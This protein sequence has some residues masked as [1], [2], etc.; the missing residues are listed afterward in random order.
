MRVL[1]IDHN[2]YA[3]DYSMRCKEAGHAVKHFILDGPRTLNIGVGLVDI[4]RDFHPW[5]NWADIIIA[6]DNVKYIRELD[7]YRKQNP[8]ACVVA[9]NQEAS[10]ME[11]DR[12][13]GM[14]VLNDNNILTPIYRK[15]DSYDKAIAYVKKEDRRF[16]SKPNGDAAKE[17]SYVAKT[18]EDMIYM[19][20]RWKKANKLK[21]TF[22]LQ[23]FIEGTEMAVGGWFG[24][25]GWNE[26]WCENWEFKKLM[27]DD[28]G[29][30]TGEQGTV[31]QH[32]RTSKLANELLKPCTSYLEKIGYVGY[33]DINC[34]IDATGTPWPLEWTM[35]F[36]WPT[37]QIQ[38]ELLDEDD[39]VEWLLDLCQG[40]DSLPFKTNQVGL[41]V[42]LTI[43]DYPYSHA[44][45]KEVT[46]IPLYG[47]KPHPQDHVHLCEVMLGQAPVKTHG[48][49]TTVPHLV[50]AGD[51]LLVMADT[52]ETIRGAQNSVYKRLKKLCIPSS[53]MYRT[54]IGD[55]LKKQLPELQAMG[56]AKM[57]HF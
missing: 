25:D 8:L 55:R 35:R 18:P 48:T 13:Q 53:P 2:G 33:V 22:I 12:I 39:P 16:V 27:N 4:I 20:E 47:L 15:F 28:L 21:D 30:A 57:L 23:E 49:I 51:Y 45:K 1:L 41:G 40:R 9:A 42:V 5:L 44:V 19:L 31:I 43:P 46:G 17:L 38:C 50:S 14:K 11:L 6:S 56:Y 32:V 36:G 52:S 24:P 37:F 54:D 26:G 29:V 3:L 7:A 34:I 10:D